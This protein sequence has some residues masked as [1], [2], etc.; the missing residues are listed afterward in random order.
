MTDGELRGH[1]HAV[2]ELI[3]TWEGPDPNGTLRCNCGSA[4]PCRFVALIGGK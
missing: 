3:A 4:W 2:A 1:H